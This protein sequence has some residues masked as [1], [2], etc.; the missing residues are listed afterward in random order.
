MTGRARGFP[1]GH[2]GRRVGRSLG[3]FLLKTPAAVASMALV[4][5]L[6]GACP[7]GAQQAPA[8]A[9]ASSRAVVRWREILTEGDVTRVRLETSSLPRYRVSSTAQPPTAEVE[10]FDVQMEGLPA[11][12]EVKDGTINTVE[13]RALPGGGGRLSFLLAGAGEAQVVPWGGGLDVLV[14]LARSTAASPA[15]SP[16]GFHLARRLTNPDG[17]AFTLGATPS[18]LSAFVLSDGKRLVV[19]ADGV[20]I[21]TA[22]VVEDFAEGPIARVRAARQEGRIRA[23]LEARQAG[24]FD[25]H[26]LEKTKDGFSVLLAAGGAAVPVA[27]A[28]VPA[29]PPATTPA[30]APVPAVAKEQPMGEKS[31]PEPRGG[32]TVLDLGFR[33]EGGRSLVEVVVS[34]AA[35]HVVRQASAQRVVVDLLRTTLPDKLKRALDTTA[36]PGPVRLIAAYPRGGAGGRAVD[37]RLVVDL[38]KPAPYRLERQGGRI[39]LVFEGGAP[40]PATPGV[41]EVRE[42]KEQVVVVEGKPGTAPAKAAAVPEESGPTPAAPKAAPAASTYTGR[43]LSMDFMDADIRNVLRLIGEVS[44]LNMVTGDDVQGKVTLRL[45]DVPWDQALDV[46]LKTKGLGQAREGNVVRIAPADKLAAE[47][48]R[49]REAEKGAEE[50]APLVS[51]ILPVNFA[52]AKELLDKVKAVLTPR[53]TVTVDDRTNALLVKDVSEKVEEARTLIRRLDTQTPQVLIEARIVE[54]SSNVDKSLGIQWG[55][56]YSADTAHGNATNWAFPNSIGLSGS[57]GPSNNFAVNLP[58]AVD[59]AGALSLTLGHVN[60]ILRLDLRLSALE[61]ANQV[62]VISSPRVTTLDNRTAEISQGQ[63]IPFTT[64]TQEKIETKS[65]DYKMTLNVTPH[66]TSDRSIIMKI[67]LQKDD[68]G[69]RT[70]AD[71]RTPSKNTKSARTEVLVKDGETTVIGGIITDDQRN[72]ESGIPFF[73]KIP[74]LGWLFKNKQDKGAK[75]ELVIFI[76]PKIVTPTPVTGSL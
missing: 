17:F 10:L 65:I 43:R 9:A 40:E 60:D 33:Q 66:V 67:D 44:G 21:P 62:R 76:T 57:T 53:G 31:E 23:V 71:G 46:I 55:G 64:S 61:S 75:Q 68:V 20:E 22:Q 36:F 25:G 7:A 52:S 49:A 54:V 74:I 28:E 16:E 30:P 11:R 14:H 35:P 3:R 70:A 4:V 24:A 37:T 29:E 73:S 8:D 51:D 18:N 19:D 6:A 26:R 34:K 50:K 32:G 2:A 48:A 13:T 58:A 1:H 15:A 63:E 41:A 27:K 5:F 45:V 42:G 59:T 69:D 47:T 56:K 38:R 12:V 39:T 72:F